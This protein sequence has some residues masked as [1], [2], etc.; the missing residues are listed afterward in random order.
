MPRVR[1]VLKRY[2]EEL[3]CGTEGSFKAE[4]REV[5]TEFPL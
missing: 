5:T 2:G 1:N 4:F 3:A